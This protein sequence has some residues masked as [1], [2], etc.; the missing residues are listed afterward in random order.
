MAVS[1]RSSASGCDEVKTY[2]VVTCCVRIGR[3]CFCARAR[4]GAAHFFGAK[5][6]RA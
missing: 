3:Q 4:N 2:E 6:G 5:P 1:L